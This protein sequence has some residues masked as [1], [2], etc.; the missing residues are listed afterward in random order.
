M[1][2]AQVGECLVSAG[3]GVEN[4]KW[5]DPTPDSGLGCGVGLQLALG[6]GL[7]DHPANAWALFNRHLGE[8]HSTRQRR[9]DGG[10]EKSCLA[11]GRAVD[12]LHG[13]ARLRGDPRNGGSGVPAF[14]EDA[15]GGLDD[16]RPG[17]RTATDGDRA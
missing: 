7:L 5:P 14:Q 6:I 13:H 8:F 17:L 11:G 4:P 16:A 10:F 1:L 9:L 15:T 12:P 2:A 3:S